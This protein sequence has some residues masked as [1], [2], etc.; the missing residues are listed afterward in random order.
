MFR[1]LLLC[2]ALTCT[3]AAALAE[4]LSAIGQSINLDNYRQD[5]KTLASDEFEGRAPL[6]AGETKTIE[7]LVSQFKDMGLQPA[8]GTSYVQEVPLAKITADQ[9]MALQMGDLSLVN[10][11]DF[12]ARTERIS[13]EITLDNDLVFAG[14]GIN[15][16][17]YNWNDY[18]GIDVKGKTVI[19]L[20]N[21]P[22]FTSGDKAFFNGRAMT[23]YG[24][25]TYKYEEA[26]RQ[27]AK[28]VFIV[29][30]T[31]AAGYGWGVV[32]AGGTTP[33]Y[34]LVDNQ[35]NQSKVGVMGWMTL[36][37]AEKVFS[38]AG[39][40]YRAVKKAAGQP[41]FKAIDLKQQVKLALRNSI[42]HKA[43][44]NVAAIL[45][46]SQNPDEWVAL[47]AHW[48]GLGMGME[49]AKQVVLNGAVD[50]ASGVAGVLELAR[51]FKAQV[52]AKPFK[53][54]LMFGAFTAEETGLIGAE[55]FAKNPPVPAKDIVA[56]L[57]IDGMNV[58]NATDYT[59]Q[60]GEGVSELE[61]YV[62]RVAKNQG[63]FVKPDPR[64]QN[65]LFFR[66]DH[67]AAA[68]QGIPS[69]LF[70]S[71]G[72]T[73]PQFIASRYHKSGDDYF[74]S[75]SLGGVLQDLDLIGQVMAELANNGDW[76]HWKA[77]SSFKEAR[78]AS[79]R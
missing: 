11:S 20:V 22:G 55:H 28:A 42:E 12:V 19:V 72:D 30:E 23:Y 7:Y 16:P 64:P 5:V 1:T 47:H 69:Y 54:T 71:L 35:Q 56:F 2:G 13:E 44:Q 51:V 37:A 61:D 46:G 34:T 26:A 59:L 29:H 77:D 74:A 3:G 17:E 25:W 75:W 78:K 21:D 73:D 66:S 41:G 53:R 52:K 36:R 32:Q 39:V 24:R 67:F 60:Y 31:M 38:A 40:D 76:P 8:F 79:G 14:Y 43:S 62:A 6:S 68:R 9:N 57:N 33:K 58:N 4:N 48:D 50:N 49:N 10:G 45:P 27:G 15:A 18:A 70:M 65:G 63:R